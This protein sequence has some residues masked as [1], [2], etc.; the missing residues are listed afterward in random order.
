MY[1][2]NPCKIHGHYSTCE[3]C[4]CHSISIIKLIGTNAIIVIIIIIIIII[5]D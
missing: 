4:H 5:I 2:T 3:G 1:C